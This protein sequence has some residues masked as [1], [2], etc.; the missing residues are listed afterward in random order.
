MSV[1]DPGTKASEA[2][3]LTKASFAGRLI[4]ADEVG[5]LIKASLKRS[6]AARP[7]K[8]C[9]PTHKNLHL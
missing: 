6:K 1:L 9:S 2:G 4:K 7:I 3:R 8:T 5:R